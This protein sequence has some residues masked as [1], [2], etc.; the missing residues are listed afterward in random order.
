M[1]VWI[2]DSADNQTDNGEYSGI[3]KF[4][5]ENGNGVTAIL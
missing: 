2:N 5:D 1:L 3:I 4:E